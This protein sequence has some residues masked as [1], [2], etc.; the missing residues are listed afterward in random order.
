MLI[1]WTTVV[2]LL[3]NYYTPGRR[4]VPHPRF[5]A[6]IPQLTVDLSLSLSGKL[7]SHNGWRPLLRELQH[8]FSEARTLSTTPPY[9]YKRETIHVF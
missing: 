3:L 4:Y 8:F 9:A 5:P 1:F 6:D 7:T 2:F